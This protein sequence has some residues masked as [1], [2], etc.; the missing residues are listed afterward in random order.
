MVD[1]LTFQFEESNSYEE[2]QGDMVKLRLSNIVTQWLERVW[3]DFHY[4]DVMIDK[5]DKFVQL[6]SSGHPRFLPVAMKLENTM[7]K[8]VRSTVINI[9]H[10]LPF[11]SQLNTPHS[12]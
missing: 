8:K 3:V 1:G 9:P 12:P 2:E 4:S 10:S 11:R 5:V 7:Q 6:V